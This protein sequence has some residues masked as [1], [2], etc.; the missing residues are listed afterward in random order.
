MITLSSAL[1]F[2]IFFS[3]LVLRIGIE[4]N[5]AKTGKKRYPNFKD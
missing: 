5:Y 2:A 3:I 1:F 4:F